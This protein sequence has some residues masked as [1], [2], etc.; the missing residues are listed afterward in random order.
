MSSG[1][2]VP[3]PVRFSIT[4]DETAVGV[5]FGIA[6][7]IELGSVLDQGDDGAAWQR[8]AFF[9]GVEGF[10]AG[11]EF[12]EL[13]VVGAIDGGKQHAGGVVFREGDLVAAGA[14]GDDGGKC[15]DRGGDRRNGNVDADCHGV[16]PS[17]C[18]LSPNLG[19]VRVR[20]RLERAVR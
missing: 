18:E 16:S 12:A 15:R 11:V 4:F 9:G 19:D 1:Y 10:R 8:L 20:P 13:L 2:S 6:L 14:R 17:R 5:F 7:G 3:Q